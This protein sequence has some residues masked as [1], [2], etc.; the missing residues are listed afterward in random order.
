[1]IQRYVLVIK[2]QIACRRE[3][4]PPETDT[5][6][7]LPQDIAAAALYLTAKPSA[8]PVGPKS[9]LTTFAYLDSLP[10]GSFSSQNKSVQIS[11]SAAF[12]LPAS[13]LE[14]ARATLYNLESH[15]L[16]ILGFQTHTALPHPLLIT[17]LQTLSLIPSSSGTL[18][19]KRALAHLNTALLSPQ[20]LYITHQPHAL[21]T[22]AIYLAAREVEVKLPECEWWEVFDVEREELG[23]LVVAMRSVEGFVQGE[24]QRWSE[25]RVPVTVEHSRA[26]IEVSGR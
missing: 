21:A 1:M 16:T 15:I 10:P 12:Y 23:F 8:T 11:S 4:T 18:V 5:L 19:A 24:R 17:Y 14:T 6:V 2:H 26:E 3:E 25:R 9:L 20:M 7:P 22:A 13:A